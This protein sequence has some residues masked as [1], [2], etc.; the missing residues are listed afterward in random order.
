MSDTLDSVGAIL[1]RAA[2]IIE[3]RGWT[4]HRFEHRGRVCASK[5]L[6]LAVAEYD[7]SYFVEG[8]AARKRC[9]EVI[10]ERLAMT[11]DLVTYNDYHAK[12]R[13]DIVGVLRE[14]ATRS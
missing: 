7:R 6:S 4:R 5:A 9:D 2:D 8:L 10:R 12:S 13:K 1:N 3:E 11:F 14:A